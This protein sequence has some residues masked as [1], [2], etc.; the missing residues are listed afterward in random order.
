M[1]NTRTLPACMA[2]GLLSAALLYGC[3]AQPATNMPSDEVTATDGSETT[4]ENSGFETMVGES[5]FPVGDHVKLDEVLYDQDGLKVTATGFGPVLSYAALNLDIQNTGNQEMQIFLESN[6][7]NG[8]VWDASLVGLDNGR[9]E[10]G[11][12]LVLAPGETKSCGIGYANIAYLEPCSIE[13]FQQIGFVLRAADPKTGNDLLITPELTVDLPGTEG[14]TQAYDD[15]GTV[16]LDK[17]GVRL[18]VRGI[19]KND[20]GSYEIPVFIENLSDKTIAVFT[21]STSVDGTAIDEEIPLQLAEVPA[22]KRALGSPWIEDLKPSSK[23]EVSFR[24]A[25]IDPITHEEVGDIATTDVVTI[26]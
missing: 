24:V 6:S 10:E 16:A 1:K 5:D 20:W 7:L 11:I 3:G 23:V 4:T 15:P 17:N 18:V 9:Y 2:A 8:W 21:A 14:Y 22:G 19:V 25:E 12:D 26:G 13:A